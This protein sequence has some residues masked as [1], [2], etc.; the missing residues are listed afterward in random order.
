M[1]LCCAVGAGGLIV[2]ASAADAG[3]RRAELQIRARVVAACPATSAAG[4][5]GVIAPGG[6]AQALGATV[7]TERSVPVTGASPLQA[8]VA[9]TR[10]V[11]SDGLR[12]VTV[13]Y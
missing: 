6:C 12:Y 13:I 7:A 4:A 9:T 11:A 2:L 5:S 3:S 1:G 10:D 8:P